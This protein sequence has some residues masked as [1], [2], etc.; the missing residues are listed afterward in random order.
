MHVRCPQCHNVIER[1][2]EA[3]LG[4]I[5]CTS[6]V[7]SFNLVGTETTESYHLGTRMLGHFEVIQQLGTG[8]FGSVWK[9]RDTELDRVVAMKTPR[10]ERL[11][12]E[13]TEVFFREARAAAQ[14]DHPNIVSVHQVG[15]EGDQIYI[16]SANVKGADFSK[17]L[18]A[19]RGAEHC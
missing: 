19:R 15:R 1:V 18:S 5:V 10:Q 8:H 2:A 3:S 17:R 13:E 16:V 7:S 4:E 14:L 6:C 12:A 9:L 11:N